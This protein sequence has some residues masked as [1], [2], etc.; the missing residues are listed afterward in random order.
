VTVAK[1]LHLLDLVIEH[2]VPANLSGQEQ[3]DREGAKQQNK[4]QH[5]EHPRTRRD[6]GVGRARCQQDAE[7]AG[8]QALPGR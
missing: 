5:A 1:R 6:A 8:R 3:E 2:R 7:N 4:Q